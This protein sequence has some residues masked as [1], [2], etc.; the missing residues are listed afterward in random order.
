MNHESLEVEED[1]GETPCD[2][3][4]ENEDDMEKQILEVSN[5]T[6]KEKTIWDSSQLPYKQ[7]DVAR[8]GKLKNFYANHVSYVSIPPCIDDLDF[9]ETKVKNSVS[10]LIQTFN[11]DSS[12]LPFIWYV[13]MKV[14]CQAMCYCPGFIKSDN[15]MPPV[16]DECIKLLFGH[17]E[18]GI[19]EKSFKKKVRHLNT[20]WAYLSQMN[21]ELEDYFDSRGSKV[22]PDNSISFL[23]KACNV[24]PM[25]K[26]L[27][28]SC[29]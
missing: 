27:E 2:I 5:T 29:H 1:E 8:V 18:N 3:G 10:K 7:E 22:C 16:C 4:G 21:Y 12:V 11:E 26:C 28:S 15:S 6:I 14:L 13:K 25:T 24:V 19:R 20:I 23:K 17:S 9:S